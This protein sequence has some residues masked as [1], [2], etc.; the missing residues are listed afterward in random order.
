MRRLVTSA[1]AVLLVSSACTNGSSPATVP[2][3]SPVTVAVVATTGPEEVLTTTTLRPGET[4]STTLPFD[5]TILRLEPVAEGFEQPVFY[6]TA[7]GRGFVVDQPGVIWTVAPD[8]DPAGFLDIR[9]RVKFGG[10]QGL[11]GLAFHPDYPDRF[12]VDYTAKDNATVV[13]EFTIEA[14]TG[15]ADP[16]SERVV[17]EVPQPAAN[18]NGGMIAFGPTGDLWI[19]M[20]DGGGSNDRYG[21]A[22]SEDTLLGAMLRIVVG[23]DV[24][25]YGIVDAHGFAAQEIW[26]IGLR[27]PWRFSFDGESIWIAD[28]GQGDI[29]EVDRESVEDVELNF[30]WPVYEGTDCFTGPCDAADASGRIFTFPMYEYT[31]DEGCSITGGYVYRGSAMPQLDGHY[32]FSDWCSGFIRSIAPDGSVHDW[33]GGTGTVPQVTSFGRDESGEIYVVSGAG[34]VYHLVEE[35]G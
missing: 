34:T 35:Q 12:Y 15:V 5:E 9:D 33:T 32:F 16:G 30:G 4:S 29:E 8:K 24:V 14:S 3:A 21:N 26:A 23:P 17:I 2:E 11:L 1:V 13:S 19:G 10:E 18:H 31:H 6:T 27:N 7:G 20:G 22:Q 28:V 25:P